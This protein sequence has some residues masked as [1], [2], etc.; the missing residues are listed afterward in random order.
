MPFIVDAKKIPDI[1]EIN[2]FKDDNTVIHCKKPT[3]EYSMKEK[4]SFVTGVSE[5]K[6]NIIIINHIQYTFAKQFN[7]H[8]G[9]ITRNYETTRT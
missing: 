3:L 2:I 5:N 4:V 1:Q 8:K 7:R 6:S 9:L